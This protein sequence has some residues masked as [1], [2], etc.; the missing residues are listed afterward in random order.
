MIGANQYPKAWAL[1][2]ASDA[3]PVFEHKWQPSK[4]K[5]RIKLVNTESPKRY[6]DSSL[7]FYFETLTP[8]QVKKEYSHCNFCE[9]CRN[10]DITFGGHRFWADKWLC[11]RCSCHLLSLAE[12]DDEWKTFWLEGIA[13]LEDALNEFDSVKTATEGLQ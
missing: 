11:P 10:P 6:K 12:S 9:R 1:I 4:W 3:D 13:I 2:A 8:E 5:A 7:Q